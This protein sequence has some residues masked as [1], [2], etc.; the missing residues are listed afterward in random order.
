MENILFINLLMVVAAA[1]AAP[2]LLGIVPRLRLPVAVLE[3]LL[4][5]LIGPAGLRLAVVD[6][7]VAALALIGLAFL[8]FLAGAEIAFDTLG[9]LIRPAALGFLLSFGLALLISYGLQA[10][11]IIESPLLLAITLAATALGIVVGILNQAN[12]TQTTFGQLVIAGAS[13]ADFGTVI[14]LTLFFSRT[15]AGV[16]VQILLVG[17]LALLALVV[18]LTVQRA[19]H[20]KRL[21]TV[22]QRLE[23]NS[24][25]IRIR[26]A[27]LLLVGFAALAERLGVEVILGAFLAGAILGL[28]D[29]EDGVAHRVFRQK[30]NAIG[31]GVFIPIFLVTTGMRFDI[32]DLFANTS[33]LMLIPLLLGVLLLVRGLPALL[34]WSILGGKSALSAGLFQAT[35]LPFIVA[36]VQIGVELHLISRS[37]GAALVAVGLLSV[38][39]FPLGALALLPSRGEQVIVQT[40]NRNLNNGLRHEKSIE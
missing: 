31:Y 18:V 40:R 32:G 37:F 12:E 39:L 38:V 2:L 4:G 19:E 30:L 14:L 25:E 13:I 11:G 8:L 21:R 26:S 33:N 1:V 6:S 36:T 16:G 28:V 24:A 9:R 3:I 5:I 34:Y 23:G 17:G 35:S 22:Q 27:L 20:S 10:L 29:R 7:T 15:S